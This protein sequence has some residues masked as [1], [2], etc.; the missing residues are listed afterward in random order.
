M[1]ISNLVEVMNHIACVDYLLKEPMEQITV[2]YIKD[3]HKMLVAG[4]VDE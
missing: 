3:L 1:K 4:A 2:K